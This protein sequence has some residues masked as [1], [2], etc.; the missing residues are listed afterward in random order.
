MTQF[1]EF[2]KFGC[3]TKLGGFD[4]KQTQHLKTN[5][6]HKQ[7]IPGRKSNHTLFSFILDFLSKNRIL[8]PH[9]FIVIVRHQERRHDE[10]WL[11]IILY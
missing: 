8:I 7:I 10:D 6:V 3:R 2:C 4:A 1:D 5:E 11:N 9:I